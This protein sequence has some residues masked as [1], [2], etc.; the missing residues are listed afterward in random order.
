MLGMSI[1]GFVMTSVKESVPDIW[2]AWIAENFINYLF[3][4]KHLKAVLA[5]T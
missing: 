1:V 2:K 3:P 5:T 4:M